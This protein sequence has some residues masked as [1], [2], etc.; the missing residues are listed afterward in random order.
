MT[1]T[2]PEL[3]VRA[4]LGTVRDMRSISVPNSWL[5]CALMDDAERYTRWVVE[6]GSKPVT[7]E[8][9]QCAETALVDRRGLQSV[10]GEQGAGRC[11][12]SAGVPCTYLG[13]GQAGNT[14][15]PVPGAAGAGRAA[16]PR[17]VRRAAGGRRRV[18]EPRL[19][20]DRGGVRADDSASCFMPRTR[21]RRRDRAR[22]AARTPCAAAAAASPAPAWACRPAW[23]RA[24]SRP[25][26]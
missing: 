19:L 16:G 10:E 11:P 25:A 14:P 7:P 6:P 15:A 24:R 23:R 20:R 12:T 8:A 22:R 4:L 5:Y 26:P 13:Q 2:S 9:R 1:G 21:G 18:Q 17:R 3:A